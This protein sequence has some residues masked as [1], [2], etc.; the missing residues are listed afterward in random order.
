M[1]L[2][3]I[4]KY[5]PYPA[6]GGKTSCYLLES[7]STKIALDF[8]SGAIAGIGQYTD[9]KAL[10]AVV[11][12]HLHNDHIADILPLEYVAQLHKIRSKLFLPF[13]ECPQ[14]EFIKAS[15]LFE[16]NRVT[17]GFTAQIGGLSLSFR[18]MPHPV[19]S[20]AVK[21]TDGKSVFVYTGDTSWDERLVPFCMGAKLV[22]MDC[23][24]GGPHASVL[25]AECLADSTGAFVI[26]THL[27]PGIEYVSLHPKVRI[28][29]E[30]E[31]HEIE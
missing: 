16:L 7:G 15:G 18:R 19:E 26:A 14:L 5:G 22:V 30:G 3:V 25:D 17:D 8:G 20:Y 12:S 24:G 10:D 28:A 1:H 2:T 11:L 9:V 27:F 23:N 29:E 13:T 31:R 4:G 21:I 6:P